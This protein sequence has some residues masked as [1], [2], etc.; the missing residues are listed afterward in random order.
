MWLH[1]KY[2][3]LYLFTSAI[4]VVILR[5]TTFTQPI[6]PPS[7]PIIRPDSLPRLWRYMN[8]LLTYNEI[9]RHCA[10]NR[11]TPPVGY[12]PSMASFSVRPHCKNARR[13]RCHEYHNCF[14]FG[15]LEETTRTSSNYVDEDYL[16]RPEIKQSLPG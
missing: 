8:L 12:C 9:E 1:P 7:S 10:P 13:D 14:P 5:C 3:T 11:A 16:A 4:S 2:G 6:L 15:E